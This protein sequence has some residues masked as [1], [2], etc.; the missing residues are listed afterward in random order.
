MVSLDEGLKKWKQAGIAQLVELQ[1]SKLEVAGSK[2]VT[3]SDI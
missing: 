3:R 1:F 2:P